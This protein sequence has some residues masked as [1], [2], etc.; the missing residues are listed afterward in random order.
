[1]KIK[2][3]VVSAPAKAG[4]KHIAMTG[5]GPDKR[6]VLIGK[7]AANGDIFDDGVKKTTNI[8]L[9]ED[10]NSTSLKAIKAKK[11]GVQLMAYEDYFK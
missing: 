9:L 7:I 4:A 10:I 8:L 5:S 2:E 3:P 1:M 6:D 11:M